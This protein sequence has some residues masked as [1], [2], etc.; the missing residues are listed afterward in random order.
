MNDANTTNHE[1]HIEA[2]AAINAGTL[3]EGAKAIYE[4][5]P[6]I[7]QDGLKAAEKTVADVFGAVSIGAAQAASDCKPAGAENQVKA[8][9]SMSDICNGRLT[10]PSGIPV[11]K[12]G[13]QLADF[14]QDRYKKP[15]V[16]MAAQKFGPTPGEMWAKYGDIIPLHP[17]ED[18]SRSYDAKNA[19]S[20]SS[21][22]GRPGGPAPVL[23]W[24]AP[25]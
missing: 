16:E 20:G 15:P 6:T 25:R 12:Q 13:R 17:D 22:V 8:D 5:L 24:A 4:K 9:V 10:T 11:D 19:A 2:P 23:D 14:D 7:V 1:N 18:A 21:A 3:V